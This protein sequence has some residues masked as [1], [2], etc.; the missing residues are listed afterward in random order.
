MTHKTLLIK[1]DGEAPDERAIK[2]AAGILKRGGL[3]AFPT[4]TVYG[5]G[6]DA[7]NAEAVQRIFVAKGRPLD[8]PIIVHVASPKDLE[9][10]ATRITA[11]QTALAERFWPGPLT[12]IFQKSER[13]PSE[14]TAGRNTAAVRMPKNAVAL[15]LIRATGH[16]IAAPSANLSGRPSPTAAEHVYEDLAG[17]IDL[18]LDGGPVEVGLESTVLDISRKPPVIL[19]PGAIT[20]EELEAIIGPVAVGGGGRLAARSPGI[21]HRHYSPRAR[22]TLVTENDA[23]TVS[24]LLE[25]HLRAS[26]SVGV[27]IH[28]SMPIKESPLVAVRIL[29]Q[30]LPLLARDLFA[31]MRELD[32][33]GIEEMIIEETEEKGIGAAVMDRLRRAAAR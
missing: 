18:I 6:A 21:R 26:R 23:G 4:E 8:N 2:K 27:I 30:E 3:V 22:V 15:A 11:K 20:R 33:M 13:L 29:P 1:V 7:L 31:V 24:R 17:R 32:Q 10:V 14:V 25:E 12:V 19:R 16:P 28:N 5:L 9:L